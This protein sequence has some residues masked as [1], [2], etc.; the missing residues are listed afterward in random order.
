MTYRVHRVSSAA[1]ACGRISENLC[2]YSRRSC[3]ESYARDRETIVLALDTKT[4]LSEICILNKNACVVDV[5]IAVD[6]RPHAYITVHRRQ[7]L[8]H[9]REMRLKVGFFPCCFVKLEFRRLSQA[10]VA[11]YGIKLV[12]IASQDIESDSGPSLC[13][14]L[15]HT[16]EHLLFGP[17]LSASL[18]HRDCLSDHVS[19]SPEWMERQRHFS[20][21]ARIER[22]E[23][24]L[25]SATSLKSVK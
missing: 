16:T 7:Q 1:A 10:S 3:W 5:S 2:Q 14:L 12:G 17:S 15:S 11:V 22:L 18:P 4:L 20:L 24:E 9:T 25:F 6:D 13:N 21:D 23:E 19:G 8:P